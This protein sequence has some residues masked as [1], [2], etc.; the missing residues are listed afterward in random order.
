MCRFLNWRV[1]VIKLNEIRVSETTGDFETTRG[2]LMKK[3]STQIP[4]SNTI[5]MGNGLKL[6]PYLSGIDHL[7]WFFVSKNTFYIKFK[8]MVMVLGLERHMAVYMAR[9]EVSIKPVIG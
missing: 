6:R 3:P 2:V 1:R 5:S 4:G 9:S 7:S 8:K